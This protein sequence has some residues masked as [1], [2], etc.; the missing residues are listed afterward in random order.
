[1]A[2]AEVFGDAAW[3]RDPVFADTQ[4]FDIYHKQKAPAPK[5][6]GPQN[7]H[8]LMRK[9]VELSGAPVSAT[10]WITGDD[11]YKF[12]INGAFVVQGPE[13]SYAFA[14]PYYRIEIGSFLREGVN[15]LAAHTYYQGLVNRVWNS[16]DNRS[17]FMIALEV[18]FADGSKTRIETDP[19]WRVFN[20]A[21]AFPMGHT[22]G[23]KTQIA[24][25]IDMRALPVGWREAGFDDS[26]WSAPLTGRQDHTFVEQITPPLE[27]WR[28]EP[29][30]TVRKGD[31]HYFYDF[32]T[33]IVGHTRIRTR[34]EAGRV[35]EVR[36]GEELL[37]PETVRYEMRA[38]CL[39]QEFPVLSGA[40][41]VVEFYDYRAFR[42]MEVLNVAD[43]PEVWVDVR[44]H[45][46]DP[47]AAVLRASD[48]LIERIWELCKNGVRYGCQGGI[49]DCPS[50]EKGQYLGDALI[51]GRSHLVLTGDPTLT[52]K[53]LVDFHH[54]QRICPGIMGVAPGSFMQEIAE[55]SLQWTLLLRHYYQYTGDRAFLTQMVDDAFPPLYGYWEGYENDAGLLTGMTEKWVL[56][57]WPGNMR[58]GYDYDYA[59]ERENAVLNAFYYASLTAAAELA[60]DAGRDGSRYAEKAARVKQSFVERLLNKDTG[61]FVDAP[62]SSHSSLHANA[63]P[64][65]FGMVPAERIPGIVAHIREKRLSCGV[66]IAPFVIEACYAV[67]EHEL[68][69]DLITSRDERSWHEMLKHGATACMEAWGPDQKGNS[70]WCHPWSS[71]PVFL[72]AERV[73]GLT[74]AEPGW[75]AIRFAPRVPDS[76]DRAELRFPIPAGF[77]TVRWDRATGFVLQVPPG[78]PVQVEAP[79]GQPVEVRES[80]EQARALT[81]DERARLVRHGWDEW[82]GDARAVW[83]SVEEQVFRVIEA[84]RLVWE[85]AC[86]TAA[87]GVGNRKD[88]YQTP[89]GWHR[90]VRKTGDGAPVGQVFRGG[91]PTGEVWRPGDSVSED[92]V[93][94]RVLFLGGEEPGVNQG[95]EVD[96]YERYIYIHGTND[97]AAIGRPSSHGCVRLRNDDVIAAYEMLSAGT[98]VLITEG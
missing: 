50:R 86:A 87:K 78:V 59:K 72:V 98:R 10:L 64:L 19:T 55:Y 68:A 92:L 2:H 90:I 5:V 44:H 33:E 1:M 25:N 46:F 85:T 80:V 63:L 67:G 89:V 58:D 70:S 3:L 31:G 49:L 16:G 73:M 74:P 9:E 24:E 56:V 75:R 82:V 94:T 4:V 34:G 36:H 60:E 38:N 26:A 51:G 97:E 20:A 42:Y 77:V 48:E 8:T 32:G 40:D 65:A 95:G 54:S 62:G 91:R 28:A 43:E 6:S 52:R 45:P 23:Y 7:V 57:D 29:R 30:V 71:G 76:L 79:E 11:Y 96:S 41:E 88:S 83:V 14:H 66:Y 84:G 15:C 81:A 69:Y 37:A 18:T 61:L 21:A 39:Y 93:L 53:A 17:G 12:Y 22:M 35:I 27:H 13:P 47:G